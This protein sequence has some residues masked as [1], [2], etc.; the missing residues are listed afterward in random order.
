[1]PA[2]CGRTV[3][4]NTT[5]RR[6]AADLVEQLHRPFAITPSHLTGL[7]GHAQRCAG[8]DAVQTQIIGLPAQTSDHIQRI[9]AQVRPHQA[10]GLVF[11]RGDD[12]LPVLA[13]ENV[14]AADGAAGHT[15]VG[16]V[17]RVAAFEQQVAHVLA[18]DGIR[19]LEQA[20]GK[21]TRGQ[22]SES[23]A[24]LHHRR[25]AVI[26]VGMGLRVIHQGFVI[27]FL[28]FF[29]SLWVSN[30]RLL[31]ARRVEHDGFQA[32]A[33]HHRAQAAPGGDARGD[34]VLIQ[35]LD[36]RSRHF[37]LAAGADERYGHLLAIF[38]E[39]PRG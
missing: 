31:T 34:F 30:G 36:P 1:M 19:L 25:R 17:G 35:V 28:R 27:D 6:G 26:T 13:A 21:V 29:I 16:R 8:F 7:G 10:D 24:Q 20:S 2:G 4:Q 23:L 14:R 22:R 3:A 39:Q 12:H 15:V 9:Y 33:A 18:A 37:H 38:F 5:Q 11:E 32:L